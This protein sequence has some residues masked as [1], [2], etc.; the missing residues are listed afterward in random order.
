MSSSKTSEADFGALG[1]DWSG[2]A[3]AAD[4]VVVHR[5]SAGVFS[6]QSWAE[7]LYA[8]VDL[9]PTIVWFVLT[10]TL[11]S[12]GV[13]TAVIWVG[14]PV[15]ALGLVLARAGGHLQR[16]LAGVLLDLPV[17]APNSISYRRPGLVGT[18][19]SVLEDRACWRAVSYYCLKILLAPVTFSCAIGVYATGLGGLTYALW[20]PYLP[21]QSAT[22]GSRHRGMQWWPDYFVDTWPRMLFLAGLGAVLLAVA[23]AV[24]RFFTT[25]DRVLIGRLLGPVRP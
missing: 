7:L 19:R 17:P 20:Q 1:S 22:D 12:V 18:L 5:R 23:P 21:Y 9:A 24:V 15:V 4:P 2:T 13:G 6:P 25:I 16:L 14:V 8:V 11:L 3:P 10:V